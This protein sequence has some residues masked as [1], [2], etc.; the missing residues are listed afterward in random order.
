[1]ECYLRKILRGNGCCAKEE[2]SDSFG[3]NRMMLLSIQDLTTKYAQ[4][5]EVAAP[6]QRNREIGGGLLRTVNSKLTQFAC[7]D[8]D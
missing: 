2:R 7:T 4:M 6:R 1:L 8:R 5:H 3:K